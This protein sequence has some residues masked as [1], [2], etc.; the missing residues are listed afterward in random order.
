MWLDEDKALAT[1]PGAV[2]R[3][4]DPRRKAVMVRLNPEREEE[5]RHA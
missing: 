1:A 2:P 3:H 5:D 4:L